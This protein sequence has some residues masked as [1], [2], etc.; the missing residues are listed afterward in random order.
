MYWSG[1]HLGVEHLLHPEQLP[2]EL[3]HAAG[4][5]GVPGEGSDA[6]DSVRSYPHR[7]GR[8]TQVTSE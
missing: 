4:H 2:G 6:S 1:P 5:R 3:V 7:E 8:E